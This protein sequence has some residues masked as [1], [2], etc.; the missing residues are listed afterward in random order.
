MNAGYRNRADVRKR[1]SVDNRALLPPSTYFGTEQSDIRPDVH[2]GTVT[3]TWHAGPG[4]LLTLSGEVLNRKRSIRDVASVVQRDAGGAVLSDHERIETG[5]EF[6]RHR[7]ASLSYQHDIPGAVHQ[8]QVDA[9]W[10]HAPRGESS[11]F[12][13]HWRTPS[14]PDAL[15]LVD[16][17]QIEELDVLTVA[18]HDVGKGPTKVEGGY[19]LSYH[20]QDI[21]SDADSLDVQQQ[22]FIPDA[23]QIYHFRLGQ[24][25]HAVYGTYERSLGKVDVLAGLRTEYAAIRPDLASLGTAFRNDYF[26]LYPTLNLRYAERKN[27]D[28]QLSY[29]RRIHRP[30]DDELNPFRVFSDPFNVVAGNPQLRPES[31]HLIELGYMM[32]FTHSTFLPSLFYRDRT[33]GIA[34]VTQSLDDSTF[35]QTPVNV[36]HDR[37]GGVES[38]ITVSMGHALEGNLTG[39]VYYEQIDATNLGFTGLRGVFSGSGS[40]NL[41]VSPWRRTVFELNPLW[42]SPKLTPQGTQKSTF[43]LNA[44]ARQGLLGDRLSVTVAVTDLL[45][46]QRQDVN[47]NVAGIRQIVTNRRDGRVVYVGLGYHF[48]IAEKHKEKPIQDDSG[49]N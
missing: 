9:A 41:T 49:D 15:N 47:R 45:K 1:F 21:R 18:L 31:T 2:D 46:T 27:A 17:G 3:M 29:G 14:Q 11:V 39:S 37:S 35:L 5:P 23:T 28:W 6:E 25:I 22:R 32:R 8:L 30:A 44:G 10:S 36:A 40:G 7:S 12:R 20:D 42:K 13:E 19:M 48:G 34:T 4:D 43:V 16:I 33:D 38:I 26:G 24:L